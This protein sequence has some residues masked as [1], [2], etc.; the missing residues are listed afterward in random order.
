[1]A[2]IALAAHYQDALSVVIGTTA[3]M[4]LA[5][6]PAVFIGDQLSKRISMKL[7]RIVAA[8]IFFGFAVV[9]WWTQVA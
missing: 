1:M 6:V 7:M 4:L 9:T 3:G 5:D 8:V 2:T